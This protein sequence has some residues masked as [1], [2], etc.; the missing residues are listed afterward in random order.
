MSRIHFPFEYPFA[1]SEVVEFFRE[2]YGPTTRAFA[3]LAESAQ[4]ALRHELTALWTTHNRSLDPRKTIV[5]AEY[6][7]VIARTPRVSKLR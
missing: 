6:L 5:D 4:A 7:E 3:V 2:N 1:P